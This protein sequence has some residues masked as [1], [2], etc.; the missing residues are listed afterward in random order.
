MMLGTG[1][2]GAVYFFLNSGF[3]I[4][5]L[6][7]LV[8]ALAYAWGLILAIYLMGHG[9]VAL[10]RRLL[11]NASVSGRLRRLQAHAP[12][13][14]DRLT[15]AI[16]ELDAYESQVVQL[17]QR[18]NGISRDSRDWIE[19]LAETSALPESRLTTSSAPRPARSTPPNVLTERYLADLTR[20]LKR[21]RHKKARFVDEWDRLVQRAQDLQTILDSRASKHLDFGR[22]SPSTGP[23]SNVKLLTPYTRYHLHNTLL[24]CLRY[25]LSALCATAS[26]AV[27]QSEMTKSV[28]PRFTLINL[29]VA[30]R[31]RV[32]PA[33]QLAAA[34]WLLYMCACALLGL[35]E[36]K[37]WGN[38]ALVRRQTYAESA[39]WYAG[40]AAKLTV[41]LA[42]NF[43]TCV[44]PAAHRRTAFYGLLGRPVDLTP[45][46]SGF[47]R[48][49]PVLVLLPVC[50]TALGWY[51]RAGRAIGLGGAV[52]EEDDDGDDADNPEGHGTGGWREGKALIERESHAG[53]GAAVGLASRAGTARA[54]PDEQRAPPRS[55]RQPLGARAGADARGD[56][57]QAGF[58]QDFAL[59]IRN[60]LET[61]DRPAWLSGLG[62]GVG[63]PRWMGGNADAAA[64]AAA[65][66]GVGGAL[67]RWF[68]GRPSE[69]RV[70]L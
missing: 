65:S 29:T 6:K 23:L 37:V 22:P 41:P 53:G 21:A 9:L 35:A 69:G 40:Q 10:P 20:K 30:P 70:R 39:A 17:R 59:R 16:D 14:H 67:G 49:F 31:A 56:D 58:L 5:S 61:A 44:A 46:G 26:L 24:P 45:L 7:A 55:A 38:R 34:A 54:A 50:A 47:S 51:G 42:Y 36:V 60:T 4:T 32:G 11:R 33:N 28:A 12:K 27:L 2:L 15:E 1:T 48:F 63:R 68:G 66:G 18:K 57:A 64:A 8:I 25:A 13:V 52:M 19:E 3:R 43:V 62:D